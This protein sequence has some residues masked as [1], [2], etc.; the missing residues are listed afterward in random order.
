MAHFLDKKYKTKI[1]DADYDIIATGQKRTLGKD[2]NQGP[3]FGESAR[4]N[5]EM[6]I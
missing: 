2:D 1:S 4:D 3:V 5:I 6:L